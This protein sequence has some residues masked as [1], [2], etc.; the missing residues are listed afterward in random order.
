MYVN[1]YYFKVDGLQ[2]NVIHLKI[3]I[4]VWIVFRLTRRSVIY[5]Y[6]TSDKIIIYTYNVWNNVKF[7]LGFKGTSF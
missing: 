2:D 6:L 1:H 7:K 5:S 3:S 4:F